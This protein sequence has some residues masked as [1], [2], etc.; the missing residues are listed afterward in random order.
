M[1]GKIGRKSGKFCAR[2]SSPPGNAAL[3]PPPDL[4]FNANLMVL[5]LRRPTEP[6]SLYLLQERRFWRLF[7]LATLAPLAFVAFWPTPV[8]QPAEAIIADT[9]D[10]LH[11]YG[12]PRWLNYNFVEASAN[13]ALFIPI[14]FLCSRAFPKSRW[15]Q[16]GGVGLIVSGCMEIGQLLFLHNRYPSPL[17]VLTNALGAAIGALIVPAALEKR[18]IIQLST[19]GPQSAPPKQL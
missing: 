15:W 1:V 16:A 7:L 11:K 14:G 6:R 2:A 19:A 8:D 5:L 3:Q 4:S 17:D 12:L 13:V 9:F 18:R 10:F